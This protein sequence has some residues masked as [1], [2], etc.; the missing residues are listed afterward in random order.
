MGEVLVGEEEHWVGMFRE[1][2]SSGDQVK[3]LM[4]PLCFYLLT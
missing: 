2:R 1:M 4:L 3:L